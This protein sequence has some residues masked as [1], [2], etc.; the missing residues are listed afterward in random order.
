MREGACLILW[1]VICDFLFLLFGWGDAPFVMM[2]SSTPAPACM[3]IAGV[4]AHVDYCFSLIL[5]LGGGGGLF[6]IICALPIP[7]TLQTTTSSARPVAL[8]CRHLWC[9][10]LI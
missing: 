2:M 9:I 3:M 10:F 4:D 7:H 5:L 6:M 8:R 1:F